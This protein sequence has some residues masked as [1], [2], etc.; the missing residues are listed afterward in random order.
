MTDPCPIRVVCFDLGGVLVRIC[1]SWEE[2]CARAGIDVREVSDSWTGEGLAQR[3]EAVRLYQSGRLDCRAYFMQMAQAT[4]ELYDASEIERIH[5][6]W[7]G[8]D[9]PGVSELVDLIRRSG[10]VRT[11]CLSNTNPAHWRILNGEIAGRG[12]PAVALLETHLVSHE[13]G[14]VK[15]DEAIYASA[16]GE[17]GVDPEA[18][19]FF[20]DTPENVEAARARRWRAHLID[21]AGD[22]ARQM[23]SLLRREGVL[24]ADA[25][26]SGSSC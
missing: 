23:L 9:Y 24:P 12:S 13:M 8:D 20:D 4:G 26:R 1:R 5:T 18:I 16:E 3:H 2:A 19:L 11:A 15:P 25:D 14:D 17:L 22:T 21:H 6:A 10:S 7:T